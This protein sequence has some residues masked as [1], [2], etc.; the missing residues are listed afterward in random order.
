MIWS[1]LQFF[2]GQ[3]IAV[4][5]CHSADRCLLGLLDMLDFIRM[6]APALWQVGSRGVVATPLRSLN[7]KHSPRIPHIRKTPTRLVNPGFWGVFNIKGKGLVCDVIECYRPFLVGNVTGSR[8]IPQDR[9]ITVAFRAGMHLHVNDM[10]RIESRA[11]HHW[12]W[13]ASKNRW[14]MWSESGIIANIDPENDPNTS[15]YR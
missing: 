9:P 7:M 11:D 1:I 2:I 3:S 4:D 6:L 8:G 15:K 5:S 10:R 13:T 14:S 12:W